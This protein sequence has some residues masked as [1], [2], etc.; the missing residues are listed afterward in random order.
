MIGLLN[1]IFAALLR[2]ERRLNTNMAAVR[3]SEPRDATLTVKQFAAEIGRS[4][5][6]CDHV[7]ELIA[8]GVIIPVR[9]KRPYLI[10]RSELDRYLAVRKPR[11]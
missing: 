3:K 9:G 7:Y 2:I 10:P 6:N 1:E 5:K 4:T 11:Y 8:N